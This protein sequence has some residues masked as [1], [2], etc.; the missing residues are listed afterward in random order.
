LLVLGLFGWWFF[1]GGLT[2]HVEEDM[3]QQAL[4]QYQI[5]W[6]SGDRVQSCAHAGIVAA[7]Y[8]QAKDEANYNQWLSIEKKECKA[9]GA[10]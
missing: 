3:L 7:T 8:L 1:G 2:S 5:A 4:A 10:R 6:R 9:A